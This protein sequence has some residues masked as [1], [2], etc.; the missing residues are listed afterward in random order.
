MSDLYYVFPDIHGEYNLLRRALDYVEQANPYGGKIIFLGDYIDRGPKNK[1]VLETVMYPPKNWE[2]ITLLG[3][4]E[5]IFL[6]AFHNKNINMLYDTGVLKEYGIEK[7]EDMSKFPKEILAWM[8]KLELFHFEDQ[9]VFAH[10]Y[11]DYSY[12]PEA[13]SKSQ[14]VWHRMDDWQSFGNGDLHLTHG[15]TPRK[16]GPISSPNRTNLDAGAVFYGKYVIGVYQKGVK[17]PYE[18]IPFEK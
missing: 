13:Q 7:S 2:Y 1:E 8:K 10:A 9:N 17:G 11:Y 16:N 5:D 4:H 18:F 6:D 12:P 15:H 14:C 3:N